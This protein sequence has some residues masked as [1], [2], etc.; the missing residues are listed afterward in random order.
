MD[1]RARTLSLP[2]LDVL[3]ALALLAI[4]EVEVASEHLRPY[5]AG[6][7]SF[8]ILTGALAWRRRAPLGVVVVGFAASLAGA[9]AGV[10]QHKPFSPILV[11][12]VAL[13]SLALYSTPRR[14]A[15]GL[16]YAAASVYGGIALAMHHGESYG[17]TDFGF[18][19]V[20]LLAPWLAGRALRGRVVHAR[21]L[22]HRVELAERG[23]ARRHARS[24]RGSPGSCT[25]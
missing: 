16:A 11:V 23:R 20:L 5:W 14:S 4:A 8:A 19:A 22:E 10:S 12:F 2:R 18:I 9:A 24:A 3:L 6:V 15:L 13:Y 1:G 21:V 25:T 7:L 17:G